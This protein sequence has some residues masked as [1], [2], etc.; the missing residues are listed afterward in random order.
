MVLFLVLIYFSFPNSISAATFKIQDVKIDAE[1]KD[2]GNLSVTEHYTYDVEEINGMIRSIPNT[3]IENLKAFEVLPNSE[4]E[5]ETSYEEMGEYRIYRKGTN[6]TVH[7]KLSY[8]VPHA[9]SRYQ[10]TAE[11]YWKFFDESNTENFSNLK[12]HLTLPQSA[13]DQ[14]TM[15]FAHDLLN[16]NISFNEDGTISY[17]VGNFPKSNMAEVR[18]LFP[19]NWL[20][21]A[22]TTPSNVKED[23]INQE[24][25][26]ASDTNQTMLIHRTFTLIVTIFLVAL[27]FVCIFV[28][29]RYD[30]ESKKYSFPYYRD[31][32]SESSPM[33]IS[34]LCRGTQFNPE[35]IYPTLL[36]YVRLGHVKMI[37]LTP[38][39]DN[40]DFKF[41]LLPSIERIKPSS[42]DVRLLNYLFTEVGHDNSFT[43][44]ELK[45]SI[46]NN[47]SAYNGL[48]NDLTESIL[49]ETQALNWYID[50]KKIKRKL[51]IP[52]LLLALITLIVTF[53]GFVNPYFGYISSFLLFAGSSYLGSF[54]KRTPKGTME[55]EKWKGFKR[56]LSDFSAMKEHP[57][58]S[59]S[60]WEHYLV[61][62]MVLGVGD[63]ALN[64]LNQ[65]SHVIKDM[66]RMTYL[67]AV[68]NGSS[69]AFSTSN[70]TTFTESMSSAFSPPPSTGSGGGSS[71]GGGGGGGGGGAGGF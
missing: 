53:L 42:Y 41:T 6:E 15:I 57:I 22:D 27:I 67:S 2:N 66:N 19:E 38:N 4:I 14:N 16:S 1:V 69:N 62:A 47:A 49:L 33:L 46:K 60:I 52:F 28:Y 45:T 30:R 39:S 50:Y 61:Y 51:F 26:W 65:E 13:N 58:T 40:T 11:L 37:P 68:S 64:Q 10:D 44:K 54:S 32:P 63:K 48:I 8:T 29:F 5:L 36:N 55:Y 9:S 31:L 34:F 21:N 20:P 12:I 3:E 24:L 59:I 7:F 35:S 70:F 25:Q 43:T 56:F 71:S 18:I 17:D 23:I